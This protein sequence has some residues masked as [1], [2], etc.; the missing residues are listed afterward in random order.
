MKHERAKKAFWFSG[1]I[2]EL[3]DD[4]HVTDLYLCEMV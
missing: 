2:E 1:L 4:A 3:L